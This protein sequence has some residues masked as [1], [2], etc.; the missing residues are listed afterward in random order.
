MTEPGLQAASV[1]I[2]RADHAVTSAK[3]SHG[4]RW[5]PQVLASRLELARC[6]AVQQSGWP[7]QRMAGQWVVRL[8]PAAALTWDRSYGL[9]RRLWRVEVLDL[10]L[11]GGHRLLGGVIQA[12][13]PA[14]RSGDDDRCDPDQFAHDC[15]D[16]PRARQG[17]SDAVVRRAEPV[18]ILRL[19]A[20]EGVGNPRAIVR[21]AP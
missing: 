12:G 14:H 10:C 13:A 16:A 15:L 17:P 21:R 4:A 7:F 2:Q 6:L 5:V 1:G 11:L 18:A 9:G 20:V 19:V 3:R 8:D